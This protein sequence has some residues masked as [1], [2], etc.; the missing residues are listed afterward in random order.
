MRSLIGRFLAKRKIKHDISFW[1]HPS[2]ECPTLTQKNRVHGIVAERG[3]KLLSNLAKAGLIDVED[4]HP[5][6]WVGLSVLS[7][8]HSPEYLESLESSQTLGRIFGLSEREVHVDELIAAQRRGVGG[9]IMAIRSVLKDGKKIAFNFGGGFHH[10]EPG[11]GSGFCVYNDVAIAIRK[12]R[13]DGFKKPI[14]IVDLDYHQGNGNSVAFAKDSSV[15]VY[16][17]NGSEWSHVEGKNDF[18]IRLPEKTTDEEYLKTLQETLPNMLKKLNPG[19]LLFISGNDV[20]SEDPMGGFE[21]T[22]EG[23]FQ[24]DRFV[25]DYAKKH[26]IPMVITLAGGYSLKALY[27]SANLLFYLLGFPGKVVNEDDTWFHSKFNRIAKSLSSKELLGDGKD[28]LSFSEEDLFGFDF[29]R[30]SNNKLFDYYSAYG[31]ELALER[32]GILPKVRDRDYKDLSITLELSDPTRQIIRV[33]GRP[34]GESYNQRLLLGEV[35]LKKE[36]LQIPGKKSNGDTA[37]FIS[38]EW[39]LLQDPKKEFSKD[40]PRLP[41]QEHP[42]LGVGLECQEVFIQMSKRLEMDGVMHHPSHYHI[43]LGTSAFFHFL[44]PK[45]EGRFRAMRE[46]LKKYPI[47]EA[48]RIIEEKR[49]ALKNGTVVDWVPGDQVHAISPRFKDYFDSKAYEEKVLDEKYHLL[50]LGLQVTK[51]SHK[52]KPPRKKI[53]KKA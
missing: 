7:L 25:V 29:G 47:S 4:V 31:V 18:D 51:E 3:K 12:L 5:S 45:V 33:E 15:S 21:M 49:L 26:K 1:Y 10:A 48:S 19:L 41:G 40:Y 28:E 27:C 43:G 34:R 2:Y 35:V 20:L 50:N 30:G 36:H 52:K 32:Y 53:K 44:D 14:A 9:T 42:G 16:S 6:P 8:F 37:G 39:L 23:V 11:N 17:I 13:R 22:V 38:I 46:I 24:R